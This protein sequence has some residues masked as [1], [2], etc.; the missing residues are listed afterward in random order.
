MVVFTFSYSLGL[1]IIPWLVQSEVFT[2]Q[3]RGLGSGISTA[4]NWTT[5]LVISATYLDWVKIVGASW[6]FWIF[7]IIGIGVS[8]FPAND[9][10]NQV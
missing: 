2:G 10:L 4:T 6:S 3:L 8:F 5:N 1:G 9:L 7:G